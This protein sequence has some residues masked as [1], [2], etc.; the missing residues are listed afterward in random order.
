MADVADV[1]CSDAR[2]SVQQ[3]FA[4]TI[5]ISFSIIVS[6]LVNRSDARGESAI[7]SRV[8]DVIGQVLQSDTVGGSVI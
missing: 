2:S 1:V 3:R 6:V 8:H 5:T 7:T 4:I